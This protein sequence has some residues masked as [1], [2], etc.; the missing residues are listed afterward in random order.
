MCNSLNTL[1]CFVSLFAHFCY[2][3]YVTHVACVLT[4]FSASLE[5]IEPAQP[6]GPDKGDGRSCDQHFKESFL[7]HSHIH[8]YIEIMFTLY[9]VILCLPALTLCQ[10]PDLN[11]FARDVFGKIDV[12]KDEAIVKAE[13]EQ[14][15]LGFDKNNDSRVSR[16][17]WSE[18][19]TAQYGHDA[20]LNHLLHAL[21]DELDTNN[22]NHVDQ[23]DI[24][25]LFDVADADK[26]N[27]V[28]LTEF[29]SFFVKAVQ[30]ATA[31]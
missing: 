13:M 12:N 10:A 11:A 15:Y 26:N 7:L 5:D 27:R 19:I 3:K 18:H 1:V 8:H 30:T 17:E 9:A 22:D 24:D 6:E 28:V 2:N 4:T 23:V 16:H 25:A 14:Y 31:G 29:T 21:Y 20:Q